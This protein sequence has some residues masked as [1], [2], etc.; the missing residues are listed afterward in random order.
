MKAPKQKKCKVCGDKY[1]PA[2]SLQKACSLPCA[3]KYAEQQREKKERKWV[4]EEKQRLKTKREVMP[5]AQRAFNRFIRERDY[6]EPCISCGQYKTDDRF[7]GGLWDC[8]HYRSTGSA[9]HLR[10]NEDNAHKQ[11]VLCNR[12][13]SGNAVDYRINLINRIGLERV[14]A[15]ECNNE[16]VKWT[17]EDLEDIKKHYSREANRLK[18]ER[19]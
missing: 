6:E 15:L 19:D 1:Q 13:K 8:G 3:L 16:S 7:T 18:K 10:F 14:E 12:D 9:P 5:E 2:N 11:C 17:K 4:R